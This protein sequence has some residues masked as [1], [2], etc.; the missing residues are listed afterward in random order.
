MKIQ[1]DNHEIRKFAYRL[2][3]ERGKP[4]GSPDEDWF[5]AE[6][7]F[8]RDLERS[9]TNLFAS[10]SSLPFSSINMGP[11]TERWGVSYLL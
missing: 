11:V 10:P 5:Q 1:I 8:R 6:R 3:E 2:W 9:L 4:V 7:R